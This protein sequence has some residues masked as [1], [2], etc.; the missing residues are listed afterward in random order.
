[1]SNKDEQLELNIRFLEETKNGCFSEVPNTENILISRS[2]DSSVFISE[3]E[4][5]PFLSFCN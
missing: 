5:Y 1:M 2:D 3:S 4:E